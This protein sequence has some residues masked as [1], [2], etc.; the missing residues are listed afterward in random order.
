VRTFTGGALAGAGGI[1]TWDG[2]SEGGEIVPSGV[3]FFRLEA[4]GEDL[5]HRGVLLR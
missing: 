1:L 5:T 4:N 3:Y 2:R